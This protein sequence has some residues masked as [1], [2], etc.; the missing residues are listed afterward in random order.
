MCCS[1]GSWKRVIN[2][3]G[4]TSIVII[5]MA[6]M[7]MQARI[8]NA[9]SSLPAATVELKQNRVTPNSQEATTPTTRNAWF[10]DVNR[11]PLSA[12]PVKHLAIPLDKVKL[13]AT[14]KSLP[15]RAFS[16]DKL[17]PFAPTHPAI[18]RP[19]IEPA[20]LNTKKLRNAVHPESGNSQ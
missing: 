11:H 4:V 20:A 3:A 15:H 12:S 6:I 19:G 9:Q 2:R 17:H 5:I 13:P 7:A 10:F 18:V 1:V 14:S 16:N 8:A